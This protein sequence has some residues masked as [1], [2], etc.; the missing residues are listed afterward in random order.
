MN[1]SRWHRRDVIPTVAILIGERQ[2]ITRGRFFG[3]HVPIPS[4]WKCPRR[5][6]LLI[7]SDSR[8]D[9]WSFL[10]SFEDSRNTREAAV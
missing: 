7:R 2:S 1:S 8:D 9:A 3:R 10:K 5:M 6:S 4:R